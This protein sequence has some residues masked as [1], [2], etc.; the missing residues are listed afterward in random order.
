MF[1]RTEGLSTGLSTRGSTPNSEYSC[2]ICLVTA[3][4]DGFRVKGL[5]DVEVLVFARGQGLE[6][7]MS[8]ESISLGSETLYP[9]L[10]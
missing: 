4:L 5:G 7:N 3:S 6:H 2:K 9:E 10:K 1:R 8:N